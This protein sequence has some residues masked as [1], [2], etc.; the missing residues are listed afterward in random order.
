MSHDLFSV[1]GRVAVVTGA[2]AGLGERMARTLHAA[3]A[4]VVV[5]G[6]RADR[7]DAL[8][9]DCPGMVAV[10]CDLERD[11]DLVRLAGTAAELGPV[12]ILV[13]NAATIVGAKAQDETREDIEA[14][15]R[16][17][18]VAPLRLCQLVYPGMA[19]RGRGAIVNVTSIVAHHGIGRL[20]QAGYA[21]SKGG[22]AALTRELAVQWAR[23][24]IRVNAIAP[25]FFRSEITEGIL[26][27]EKI[28]EFILRNTPLGR[29]GEPGDFDGALLFLAS[30]ASSFVTGQTVFVD[31]GWT[32]R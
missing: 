23:D 28:T 8:V 24:G 7:L 27:S 9:A 17:N 15:L 5:A 21:G 13:N 1:A 11:E 25:G 31:G 26:G 12:D 14:T 30:D 4:R 2:T 20:P 16:V 18:L 29:V 19:E 22:L 32:A 3:Q 6:R 10:P